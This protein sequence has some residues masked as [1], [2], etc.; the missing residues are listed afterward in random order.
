[1]LG[2]RLETIVS[3]ATETGEEFLPGSRVHVGRMNEEEMIGFIRDHQVD[4]IIDLSHP[5]AFRVSENVRKAAEHSA[6]ERIRYV[7]AKSVSEGAVQVQSLDECLEF[8]KEIKG[9]VFLTTGSSS[10]AAFESVRKDNRFVYRILPSV[11]SLE[12]CRRN[13]IPLKNIVAA[14]GPF[15]LELNLAMFREYNADYVVMKNSGSRGGTVDK[16]EACQKLG[17]LPIIIE[18][19][20][21]TGFSNLDELYQYVKQRFEIE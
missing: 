18:R 16:L 9:C 10:I 3:V 4:L 19:A 13:S 7:R 5:Y 14:L 15:S 12:V 11:D 1:M 8:L 17:I 21:E 20:S 6:C 2:E